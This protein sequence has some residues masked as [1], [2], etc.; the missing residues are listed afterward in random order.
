VNVLDARFGACLSLPAPR[1]SRATDN[2]GTAYRNLDRGALTAPPVL[3]VASDGKSIQRWPGHLPHFAEKPVRIFEESELETRISICCSSYE[4][5]EYSRIKAAKELRSNLQPGGGGVASKEPPSLN[6]LFKIE[7]L[8]FP[9]V[10]PPRHGEDE[11]RNKN[12]TISSIL[13]HR[14]TKGVGRDE[15]NIVTIEHRFPCAASQPHAC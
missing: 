3:Q 1:S 2:A 13:N 12:W 11:V 6:D 10:G 7:S 14:G 4:V 5:V 9:V 8:G 15:T